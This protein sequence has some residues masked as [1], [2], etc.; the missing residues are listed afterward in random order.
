M[1]S[2]EQ[3]GID[4]LQSSRPQRQQILWQLGISRFDFLLAIPN[5]LDNIACVS[6]FL[7]HPHQVKF[8]RLV[9]ANLANMNLQGVNLIRGDLSGANL[10]NTCFINADLLF[11]NFSHADLRGANLTGA[12]LNETIW[13]NALVD[14]CQFGNGSGL[15]ADQFHELSQ[16]GAVFWLKDGTDI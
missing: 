14:G 6:D 13:N 3:V 12:T 2:K 1:V 7:N 15:T 10:Q 8:P 9:G 11:A 16:R 5:H 4:F